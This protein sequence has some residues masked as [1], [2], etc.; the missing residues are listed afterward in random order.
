MEKPPNRNDVIAAIA[1]PPGRGGVG[2]VRMSGPQL[3]EIAHALLGR[4]PEQRKATLSFFKDAEGEVIDEGI[5]L[6][7]AAPASY[8]GEDVLE[9]QGHGGTVV[10]QMLLQRCLQ[11]GARLAEPGEFTRRAFLNDKLDL[12]QAESVADVIEAATETA[13]RCALRSLR[14]EF[15]AHI[16]DL[17]RQL[18][19]LRMLVEATLDFPEEEIDAIDR[20]DALRRLANL[21]QTLEQ[22]LQASKRGS[23]LRSGIQVVLAGRPNV[24]KS[25]LLN[26]LSGEEI[27]IVTPIPGTTRDAL[28][29]T[30]QLDGVP[31][32][33]IDTAGLRETS[34]QVE[35]I[36][37][38]RTWEAVRQSDLLLFVLE[39]DKGL[40]ADDKAL[41]AQFPSDRARLLVHNKSDLAS[42]PPDPISDNSIYVS[43]KTGQG[44]SELKQLVLAT[45]GWRQGEEDVLMA[46]ER[47]IAALTDALSHL[48][49]AREVSARHEL[50]AEELRLAHEQLGEITGEFTADDMLGEIFSRFCVGK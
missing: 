45:V 1:T 9:L 6:Y 26:R 19:E 22:S 5:V 40:T 46:R 24:G 42:Q 3:A 4:L 30:I 12:A 23:L 25:S 44:M 32:N 21:T 11:L 13:A 14:G 18:V 38:A 49:Q 28:R 20:T 41:I 34:D 48:D 17:A 29:Q 8:T 31:L 27:A 37:I 15:S 10:M 43:A 16:E 47:H 7:F 35:S 39:A 50:L 2:I 33:I 36:G